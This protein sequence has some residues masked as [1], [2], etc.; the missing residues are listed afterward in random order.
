MFHGMVAW[1]VGGHLWIGSG[2]HLDLAVLR[3]TKHLSSSTN[4]RFCSLRK[5]HSFF[6]L[7]KEQSRQKTIMPSKKSSLWDSFY[8][9][10][11]EWVL[12]V[13]TWAYHCRGA[14]TQS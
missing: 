6:A 10:S 9:W 5:Q 14:V 1:F 11:L 4:R 3:M 7:L 8:G 2:G 12:V 13:V